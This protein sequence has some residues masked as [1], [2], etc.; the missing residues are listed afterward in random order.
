MPRLLYTTSFYLLTVASLSGQ[1]NGVT[2]VAG[3][4][5]QSFSGDGGA[6]TAA[7]LAFPS[8]IAL[9]G[10]G[11]LYIAD[12]GNYRVRRVEGGA[13]VISTVAGGGTGSP[14]APGTSV[15]L[16]GPCGVRVTSGG[17]LLVSDTCVAAASGGPGG[18]GGTVTA[19][20]SRILRLDQ[21]SGLLNSL[22][23]LGSSTTGEF[24]VSP[25]GMAVDAA[26]NIYFSDAYNNRILR[27]S[28]ANGALSLVAGGNVVPEFF[29]DGY[30]AQVAS[31]SRPAGMT[32]DAA[33]NLYFCDAGNHRVRRIDAVTGIVSTVAGNG[34]AAFAGNGGAAT[35]ASFN[36]PIDVAFDAAG[37]LYVA[38]YLNYQIRRVEAGTG[39]VSTVVG[40]GGDMSEGAPPLQAFVH[41]PIGLAISPAGV[42]Y[43]SEPGLHR[44]RSVRIATPPPA[45][46]LV[47]N[48]TAPYANEAF[49]LTA[50]VSPA[51]SSG[52][53]T[54][55]RGGTTVLGSANVSAAGIATLSGLTL[56][57]GSY[58]FTA[59]YDA[60]PVQAVSTPL[61]LTLAERLP[62]APVAL[63][64]TAAGATGVNLVWTAGSAGVVTYNV[65][66]ST[67]AGFTPSAANRIGTTSATALAAS[68]LTPATT[69]YF[70]VRAQNGAGESPDSN[71]ASAVTGPALACRVTYAVTSQTSS[72]FTAAFTIRNDGAATINSWTLT[73]AW[74]DDRQRLSAATNATWS[75]SGRNAT[76]RGTTANRT[77]VPGVT[78]SGVGI[79]AS[80]RTSNPRPAA[81]FLN[82]TRCN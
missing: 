33:G 59:R 27:I 60:P 34:A 11:N 63:T 81:F 51:P 3:N 19:S 22:A 38:D 8:L 5:V 41:A 66:A 61:A 40:G 4:G 65:Y 53:V 77:L 73:W 35:E 64:A 71:Q 29:G 36:N 9:D 2:T 44:V 24:V 1:T 75:Q 20:T 80:Y 25:S 50:T 52:T 16:L 48:P 23:G 45:V 79:T 39:I 56:A 14:T 12:R 54:F 32:F 28:A 43:Y 70:R 47:A 31:L 78:L 6:A 21:G 82:G 37:H 55:L 10:N 15:Q 26:G 30:P 58:S 17:A 69:Y 74:P 76:L 46:S 68:A 7:G 67:T 49:S 57:P 13:G 62:A 18:G 42:L 72:N